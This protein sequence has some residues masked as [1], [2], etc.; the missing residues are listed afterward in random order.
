MGGSHK[1]RVVQ[2]VN[3]GALNARASPVSL[4]AIRPRWKQH[5]QRRPPPL[6]IEMTLPPG[7]LSNSRALAPPIE[8]RKV[9]DG[10]KK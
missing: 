3:N 6:S 8:E 2:D 10:A 7:F 1:T 5:Q 4:G 9:S